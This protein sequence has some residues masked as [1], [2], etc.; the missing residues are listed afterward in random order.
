MDITTGTRLGPYE[1]VAAI[2][3]G[4]MGEVYRARDSRMG[5]DVAV[6]LLPIAFVDSAERKQ[7]FEQEARTTASLS[8]PNLLVVHD[9]GTHD[10]L[11]FI[12]S[13]LLEG[14]TLRERMQ[15]RKV[16]AKKALAWGLQI[17]EG[18]AAAHDRHVV[19]RDLKPENIFVTAG[20][21]VK[22]LDFGLA[23]I[24]DNDTTVASGATMARHTEPGLIM[25]TPA[26]MSPEQV[27]GEAIDER[28]DIFSFAV[29]L[30]EML[31]GVHPFHQPSSV[32]TMNAIM[33]AEPDFGK[34][35]LP[36]AL[37][38]ILVHALEKDPTRRFQSIKDV[39]FALEMLSGSGETAQAK[40]K[41]RPVKAQPEKKPPEVSLRRL[42]FRR[43]FIMTARFAPDGSVIYGAAWE[44][45]PL[46]LYSSYPGNPE[47]RPLGLTNTDILAI[48]RQGDL[49]VSLGR[50]YEV[51]WVTSGTLG[52]MP[53]AGAVPRE[54]CEDMQDADWSADGKTFAIIRRT[55]NSFVL[56]YPFGNPVLETPNWISNVRLSPK[57][58]MIAYLDHPIW[59]DDAGRVTV[60]DMAG[61]RILQGGTVWSST[62]GL[63][64]TPKGD[65]IWTA[66]ERRLVGRDLI[67]I[68]LNGKERTVL[69]APGRLTLHDIAANG[70]V[71]VSYDGGRREIMAGRRGQ[72]G[73]ER[74]LSWFD[75]SFPTVLSRDGTKI[76]F[77]EQGAGRRTDSNSIYMRATDG[78][79]A[80]YL[81]DGRARALSAD[82]KWMVVQTAPGANFEI[83]PTGAGQARRLEVQGLASA[84]WWYWY[85]DGKRLLIW[86]HE[87]GGKARLFEVDM[88]TGARSMVGPEE[89]SWPVAVKP[90]GTEIAA[91]GPGGEV[92]IY[93]TDGGDPR[94]IAGAR[95]GDHP[96]QWSADDKAIFVCRRSRLRTTIDRIDLESGAR[97]PWQEIAP[98]DP[99]GVMDIMPVYITPDGESYVYGFRRYLSELYVVS[100]LL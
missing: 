84:V 19:H 14:S 21:R 8:H 93:P 92:L 62:S 68:T 91:T 44:D 52:R 58:D 98:D 51:G 13:E 12:V 10:G 9:V 43:G 54:I 17:A 71:L 26:Y 96:I 90:D 65:E 22:L 24:L 20:D 70:E 31:T 80:V 69:P 86:G 78:A 82:A 3:A 25:G 89:T 27:R 16:P 46:Q 63:A 66:C 81:G 76:L 15:D 18:L 67:A 34:E 75:W 56:E 64:W 73:S 77:E 74:N 29:V 35:P 47:S 94:P 1:V 83:L 55:K 41:S 87:P 99:A 6:K 30:A 36:P 100:G 37:E 39:A 4:G 45:E 57:N 61:K 49:A 59:G 38:R 28:G 33:T 48:S 88:A 50:H 72:T 85:A 23:K 5:R 2:G 11:P 7:R 79:P 42:S 97:E 60:I 32:A 95:A 40:A 53:M